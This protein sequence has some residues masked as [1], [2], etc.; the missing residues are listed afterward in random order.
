MPSKSDINPQT[1]KAYAINPSTNQWDDNYF[2]TQVEP[3]LKTSSGMLNSSSATGAMSSP[4]AAASDILKFNREANQPAIQAYEASRKPLNERYDALLSS[5]K[6]NQ[7]I[8]ED[9]ETLKVNNSMAQRG[10]GNDSNLYNREMAD[11]LNPVTMQYTNL[12]KDTEAGR[13]SDM[14]AI[15]KAIAMLNTGDPMAALNM[16]SNLITTQ[17]AANTENMKLAAAMQ[18]ANKADTDVIEAG[19]R[20]I[21][22]NK[23]TGQVIRDLGS[24]TAPVASSIDFSGLGSLLANITKPTGSTVTTPKFTSFQPLT[25]GNTSQSSATLK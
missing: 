14:S 21:L 19:G 15:D 20:K 2:A 11:S 18:Q 13:S 22:I 3:K 6:T 7:K 4:I 24:S 5:I 1:G 17:N 23:Q 12:M 9:R 16:A 25:M 10:I 8:S